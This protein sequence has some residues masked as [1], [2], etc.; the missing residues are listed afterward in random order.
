MSGLGFGGILRDFWD[1][2]FIA[3]IPIIIDARDFLLKT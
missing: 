3:R 2:D 1:D